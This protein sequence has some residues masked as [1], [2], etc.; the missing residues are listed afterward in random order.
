M[1]EPE[2]PIGDDGKCEVDHAATHTVELPSHVDPSSKSPTLRHLLITNHFHQ[3]RPAPAVL[4]GAP[5]ERDWPL[6]ASGELRPKKTAVKTTPI[7]A[8]PP[9]YSFQ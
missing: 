2:Q 9:T 6:V 8:L 1:T 5:F 3:R 7:V 4:G